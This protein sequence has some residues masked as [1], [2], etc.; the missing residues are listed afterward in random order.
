MME[1]TKPK[2]FIPVHG[3]YRHLVMHGK[4]AAEMGIP[5]ENTFIAN[6]GDVIELT[7]RSGRKAGT[8]TSGAV[9][10]D[11]IGDI[12]DIVLKDRK[13]LS[14]DGLVVAV[15]TLDSETGRCSDFGD[16]FPRVC[17][18]ARQRGADC[19]HQSVADER[20]TQV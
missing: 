11:G 2:F 20:N 5:P 4:L 19:G 3:E 14:Q 7:Q 6:C 9:M 17:V 15:L 8:V 10:V 13:T 12:D 1:L 16:R 18:Y